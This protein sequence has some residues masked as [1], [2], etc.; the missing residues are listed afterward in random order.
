[1]EGVQGLEIF[2]SL[3]LQF[4]THLSRTRLTTTDNFTLFNTKT[5]KGVLSLANVLEL[6]QKTGLTHLVWNDLEDRKFIAEGSSFVVYS[7]KRDGTVVA[8]KHLKVSAIRNRNLQALLQDVAVMNHGPLRKHPNILGIEGYGWQTMNSGN[9]MS[10]LPFLAVEF[11]PLGCLRDYLRSAENVSS[12]ISTKL[13]I[14]ADIARGL[15]SLHQCGIVHGDMKLENILVFPSQRGEFPVTVKISD[16][17]HALLLSADESESLIY[18]GTRIYNAPEVRHQSEKPILRTNLE[19]CDIWSLGI[20]VWEIVLD[21]KLFLDHL[22]L[23]Q[24]IGGDIVEGYLDYLAGLQRGALFKIAVQT[25][26]GTLGGYHSNRVIQSAFIRS[27]LKNTIQEN[28]SDRIDNLLRLPLVSTWGNADHSGLDVKLA[29]HTGAVDWTYDIFDPMRNPAIEWDHQVGVAEE[30]VSIADN[31]QFKAS[32]IADASMHVASCY[33]NG[34]GV[35]IDDTKAKQYLHRAAE[36]GHP[37]A[38]ALLRVNMYLPNSGSMSYTDALIDYIK[39]SNKIEVSDFQLQSQNDTSNSRNFGGVGE[40]TAWVKTLTK[41]ALSKTEAI[42]DSLTKKRLEYR[43]LFSFG[44][45]LGATELVEY[46][47]QKGVYSKNET[48]FIAL[49]TSFRNGDTNTAQILLKSDYIKFYSHKWS[50]DAPNHL[51]WLFMFGK[52]IPK[53]VNLLKA[54]KNHALVGINEITRTPTII[55]RQWPVALRGSP[56]AFAVR[57][58]SMDAVIALIELGAKISNPLP[59][60]AQTSPTNRPTTLEDPSCGVLALAASLHRGRILG[61]MLDAI[62]DAMPKDVGQEEQQM[63][64][65]EAS[66]FLCHT[67]RFKQVY[68]NNNYSEELD[69][70]IKACLGYST[71]PRPELLVALAIKFCNPRLLKAVLNAKPDSVNKAI[72]IE[73]THYSLPIH[74]AASTFASGIYSKDTAQEVLDLLYNHGALINSKD[75]SGKTALYYCV[76]TPDTSIGEWFQSKGYDFNVIDGLAGTLLHYTISSKWVSVILS[77]CDRQRIIS[78]RNSAGRT[79]LISAAASSAWEAV[80][81]L[82]REGSDPFASGNDGQSVIHFM[83]KSGPLDLFEKLLNYPGAGKGANAPDILQNTPLHYAVISGR[84]PFVKLLLQHKS[85]PNAINLKGE[86]PVSKAAYAENPNL[87]MIEELIR[88]GGEIFTTTSE[89]GNPLIHDLVHHHQAAAVDRYLKAYSEARSGTN[90]VSKK[91]PHSSNKPKTENMTIG[92]QLD[93]TRSGGRPALYYAILLRSMHCASTLARHGASLEKAMNGTTLKALDPDG[94]CGFY[95][96]PDFG[97]YSSKIIKFADFSNEL[98]NCLLVATDPTVYSEETISTRWPRSLE[99]NVRQDLIANNFVPIVSFP[100]QLEK[101]QLI[102][103]ASTMPFLKTLRGHYNSYISAWAR[104]N[105]PGFFPPVL[106]QSAILPYSPLANPYAAPSR[107]NQPTSAAP[108]TNKKSLWRRKLLRTD[109]SQEDLPPVPPPAP[110]SPLA[111]SMGLY[112]SFP[113]GSPGQIPDGYASEM[114]PT[115]TANGPPPESPGNPY[116]TQ[117]RQSSENSNSGNSTNYCNPTYE[118]N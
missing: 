10:T 110:G 100:A 47:I 114:Y 95:H 115:D 97:T 3:S 2:S 117:A 18:R 89:S 78:H 113:L 92:T 62:L 42:R 50:T 40:L 17:G 6:V 36:R 5:S 30:F 16:F 56:L 11:A 105:K 108:G 93:T 23:P 90:Q 8:V 14:C 1:M 99:Y 37:L 51:H 109:D 57:M 70:T 39:E 55:H 64:S 35:A 84:L 118:I 13:K 61:V 87:N 91:G 20:M 68:A 21:G 28:P 112:P 38:A 103:G 101:S 83:A 15:H 41:D 80:D 19:K 4:D 75:I 12:K 31:T 106:P 98:L 59:L 52:D 86:S 69:L 111:G 43:N 94:I 71:R 32:T 22:Q 27:I 85:N 60:I 48:G 44:V 104:L 116:F 7:S 24:N 9:V 53:I 58:N 25:T 65:V 29:M 73:S 77:Y 54:N 63:E 76:T 107:T 102:S 88:S 79:A 82:L 33:M 49:H 96:P 67:T 45:A 74:Y 26:C 72:R 66:Q 46:L 34:F 81:S